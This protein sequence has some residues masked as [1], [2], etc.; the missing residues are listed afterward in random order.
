[1]RTPV[2][3]FRTS[4]ISP[5]E[6]SGYGL[7][8][9]NFDGSESECESAGCD[10]IDEYVLDFC[11]VPDCGLYCGH[12]EF[13]ICSGTYPCSSNS[14]EP[15]CLAAKCDWEEDDDDDD[16]RGPSPTPDVADDDDDFDIFGTQP[17]ETPTASPTFFAGS[18]YPTAAGTSPS[19]EAP[20][21]APDGLFRNGAAAGGGRRFDAGMRSPSVGLSEVVMAASVALLVLQGGVWA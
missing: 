14:N 15:D 3:N 1:M 18:P 12:F 9:T 19:R 11:C 7:S 10:P 8:C 17:T 20:A 21:A 13:G 2:F 4:R 16:D 6:C 5:A